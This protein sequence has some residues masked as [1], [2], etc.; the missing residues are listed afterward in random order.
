MRILS[1]NKFYSTLACI[2]LSL[3]FIQQRLT[4]PGINSEHELRITT[5]D[6]FG[7]YLYLPGTFIYNDLDKLQWLD[8]IDS[9]Y[10][11]TGG[12][13]VQLQKLENGNYVGKYFVGVSI[14]QLPYFL[15]GH[16]I[17]SNSMYKPD[18]FS[19]PYQWSLSLGMLF[20]CLLS[21]FILRNVLLRYFADMDVA[22]SLLLLT[23]ASNAIQ[24]LALENAMSHAPLFA[25]YVFVL[26]TTVKWHEKPR[27]IWAALT[28]YLI[29][30]ASICRPT[31]AIIVLIPI[32]W[33]THN[34]ASSSEKWALVKSY[35]KHAY[36]AMGFGLL[37]I[38]PQL[39]YWQHVTGFFIYDVGSAW[40]FLTP[41]FRVLFGWE[42][43]W[44]IYTPVTILF[45]AGLFFIGKFPFR[46][47]VIAFCLINI[48]IVIS[49]R[50]WK[51]GG[52]Y[53]TR[54]LV[55]SYPI[56]ALG[57]TALI[58]EIRRRK[59]T[60]PLLVLSVY[61]IY[62]N[63]FQVYQYFNTYLHY[64]DMNRMYYSQIYL[65]RLPTP[66][67]CSLLDTEDWISDESDFVKD[68][69]V[70]SK[71]PIEMQGDMYS[72]FPIFELG[73][74]RGQH[75]AVGVDGYLKIT[76]DIHT[77]YGLDNSYLVFSLHEGDSVLQKN[78][79]L[80][81]PI[82]AN[83]YTNSYASYVGVPNYFAG[84]VFRVTVKPGG[85]YK[86]ILEKISVTRFSKFP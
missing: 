80:F 59:W 15:V 33:N 23:L 18:G 14:L 51:Y 37:G 42:K 35:Q 67:D 4:Y 2:V 13:R 69:S 3:V 7:Y 70:F 78:I 83:G 54:A 5:W 25:I 81:S 82:S 1:N 9:V 66:L 12:N 43:G 29:G 27:V 44:F 19:A 38:L 77:D 68:D 62:V 53:S 36:I 56:F 63:L 76:C 28:G 20:F 75:A 10:H 8:K 50:D 52:G 58:T 79:R 85:T 84:G 11:V 73:L 60:I 47:A 61:F 21:F 31:D 74:N 26:Y 57:L 86:G 22:I 71:N 64:Y 32:L 65:K 49:W 34:K 41:H 46:K 45:M 40:D 48:Y 72:L 24:Y 39:I 30:I 17:A 6:A 16:L 55:Q